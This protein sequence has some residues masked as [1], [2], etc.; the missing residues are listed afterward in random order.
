[1]R[2]SLS[3]HRKWSHVP[4]RVWC[5]QQDGNALASNTTN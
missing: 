5:E 2:K 4:V 1:M 3:L